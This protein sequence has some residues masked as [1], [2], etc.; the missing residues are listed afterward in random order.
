MKPGSEFLCE[1]AEK[2]R[3]ADPREHEVVSILSALMNIE[4]QLER[5]ANTLE[6]THS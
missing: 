4:Y 3:N 1:W 2:H 6:E 5:I